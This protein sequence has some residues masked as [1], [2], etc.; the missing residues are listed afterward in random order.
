MSDSSSSSDIFWLVSARALLVVTS[1]PS[2]GIAAARRREHALAL[3]LHHAGAAVAVRAHAFHVAEARNLDAVRAWR[4]CEH[5]CR[6]SGR[7][8][9]ERDRSA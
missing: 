4:V 5:V 3:D 7:R 9:R 8:H 6:P 2:F 1:I